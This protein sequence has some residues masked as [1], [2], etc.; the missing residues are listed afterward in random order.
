[1][2]ISTF[3]ENDGA[4][5]HAALEEAFHDPWDHNPEPFDVWWS[6]QRAGQNHDPS[7]WFFVADG[8]EIAAVVRSEAN[9]LGG[10]YVGE[11]G[12]R[13]PWWGRGYGRA[14][15]LHTFRLFQLR[16]M[17]RAHLRVDAGNP[18]GAIRLYENVGM[19]VEL[20]T[21]IWEK[22]LESDRP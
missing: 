6:R 9:F 21:V 17:P 13:P 8:E 14:L 4:R 11:L 2:E 19:R 3:R 5:F 1:L 12:V 18:T 22:A 20:E 7:P 15:L 10:G 16:G